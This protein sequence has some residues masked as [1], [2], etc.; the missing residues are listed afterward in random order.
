MPAALQEVFFCIS[1]AFYAYIAC[2][3]ELFAKNGLADHVRPGMGHVLFAL[4][5]QDDVI[6]RTSSSA[7][8]YPLRRSRGTLAAMERRE[9]ITRHRDKS[10][11]RATRS[12][13]DPPRP[14]SGRP[15]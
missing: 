7:R 12:A 13:S 11:G 10:D 4:F 5:D 1:R 14:L 9:L 8:S 2:L 3:E 6:I 15:L